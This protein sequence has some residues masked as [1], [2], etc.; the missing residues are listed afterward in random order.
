MGIATW[1]VSAAA[2]L[3]L[4]RTLLLRGPLS[5]R[6]ESVLACAAA[7]CYGLVATAL[8]FG[9]WNE[10]DWRAAV[11][12]FLGALTSLPLARAVAIRRGHATR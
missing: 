3:T 1:L 9:G 10:P 2:A 11:F 7:C 5:L 12:A 6:A 8:D 4:A